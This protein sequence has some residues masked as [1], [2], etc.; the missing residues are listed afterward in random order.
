MDCVFRKNRWKFFVLTD[1][2]ADSGAAET[3]TADERKVAVA[4]K[5]RQ[6]LCNGTGRRVQCEVVTVE[7]MENKHLEDSPSTDD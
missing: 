4:S 3:Y 2:P 6:C 1:Y 5:E 7:N